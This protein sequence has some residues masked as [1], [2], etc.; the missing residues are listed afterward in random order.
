MLHFEKSKNKY[1]RIRLN[2]RFCLIDPWVFMSYLMSFMMLSMH[3][4]VFFMSLLMIS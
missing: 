4:L 1:P 2:R 3:S